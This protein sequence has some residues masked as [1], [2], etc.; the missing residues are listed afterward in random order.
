MDNT[1]FFK[2]QKIDQEN[3][4]VEVRFINYLGPIFTGKKTLD[5]YK[6][7]ISVGTGNF[8]SQGEELTELREIYTNDNPNEDLIYSID[9]PIDANGEFLNSDDLLKHIARH[10][11]REQFVRNEKAKQANPRNDIDALLN[12]TFEVEIN[13]SNAQATNNQQTINVSSERLEEIVI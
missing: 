3:G 7:T 1:S 9:I 11:P 5:D 6:T 8:T 2:I 13:Y 10:Y 4:Y 12:Q